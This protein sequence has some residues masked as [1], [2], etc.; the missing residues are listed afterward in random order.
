M[1]RDAEKRIDTFEIKPSIDGS[2]PLSEQGSLA[3]LRLKPTQSQEIENEKTPW[4]HFS[5]DAHS[6]WTRITKQ[7]RRFFR[8]PLSVTGL[9]LIV[10]FAAIALLAP[11]LAPPPAERANEPYRMPRDGF[12]QTPR[13]PQADAWQNFPPDWSK[14]PLGTIEGQYD[15]YYGIVWGARNAFRIGVVVVSVALFIGILIGSLSGYFGGWVDMVLMRFVDILL[16]FPTII[17]AVVLVTVIGNQYFEVWGI[18]FFID[19][20]TALIIAFT[21]TQWLTYARLIRGDILSVKEKEYVLAAQSIGARDGR[22]IFKHI[23][24]NVIFPVLIA[25]SLD[26]GSVVLS[27]AGLSFLGLGPGTDFADWGQIISFSRE[28]IMGTYGNPFNY[29]YVII[30]P[31]VAIT[32][33]VLAWNLLG[34]AFRDILDPRLHS[35]AG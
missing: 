17:L 7:S 1:K 4:R 18:S 14:H 2:A 26:I 25:A 13:P 33:F 29:W 21:F 9:V 30:I 3:E 23:L 34:D 35:R 27:V 22:I 11:W 32:L 31:S 12:A 20:L 15:I 24:P 28:W 5:E 16:S 8:N 6:S 10:F 19:R